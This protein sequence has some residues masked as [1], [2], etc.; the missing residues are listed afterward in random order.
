[1][2]QTT[3]TLTFRS[4]TVASPTV[5]SATT[6]T[7]AVPANITPDQHVQNIF[8]FGAFTFTD[9]TGLYTFIPAREVVKITSP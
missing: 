8:R 2:A 7:V 4:Y 6:L 9:T 3:V 1:M 5:I